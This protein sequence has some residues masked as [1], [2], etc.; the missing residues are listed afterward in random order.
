M[1]QQLALAT[2]GVSKKWSWAL[3]GRASGRMRGY[4]CKLKQ[5]GFRL[6]IWKDLVSLRAVKLWNRFFRETI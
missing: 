5:V 6:D 1:C 4:K 3:H 2:K